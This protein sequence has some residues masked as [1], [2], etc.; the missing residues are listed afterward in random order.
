MVEHLVKGFTE[1]KQDSIDLLS[2]VESLC[3]VIYGIDQLALAGSSLSESMLL[4]C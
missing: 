2:G 3:E 1:I 4:V